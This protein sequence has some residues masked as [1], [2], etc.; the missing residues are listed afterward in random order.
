MIT[1]HLLVEDDYIE[2]FVEQLPKEKVIIIEEDFQENKEK[3]QA[4]LQDYR[5]NKDEFT[6]YSKSM[7]NIN[8]W[9][10]DKEVK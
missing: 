5:D 1:L 4:V 6:P 3:L 10:K 7:Q 8:E 9:L 2:N